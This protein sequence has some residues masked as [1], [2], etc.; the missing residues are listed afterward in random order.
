MRPD[1]V[2]PTCTHEKTRHA[3]RPGSHSVITIAISISGMFRKV[4]QILW[5]QI[6]WGEI[7]GADFLLPQLTTPEATA[8]GD[9]A[10]QPPSPGG[11]RSAAGH[12]LSPLRLSKVPEMRLPS[13]GPE[14]RTRSRH[15][16]R[17]MIIAMVIILLAAAAGLYHVSDVIA[18]RQSLQFQEA[19]LRPDQ[20]FYPG[21]FAAA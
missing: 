13:A 18:R 11:P 9:A 5:G 2:L 8:I 16:A 10:A 19:A 20:G 6:L 21:R 12:R 4:K 15:R 3:G 17:R 7:F 1:V 14:I